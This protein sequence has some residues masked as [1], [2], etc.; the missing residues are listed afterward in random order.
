ML[1]KIKL[2]IP[3]LSLIF[4]L[5]LP[6]FVLASDGPVDRLTN[7][8]HDSGYSTDARSTSLPEIVGK[9]IGVFLT[10]LGVVFLALLVYAGTLWMIAAGNEDKVTKSKDTMRRSLIGLG[11]VVAAYAISQYIFYSILF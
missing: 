7:V 5:L 8:A 6:Y 4:I 9:V 2:I 1:K 11:I 10:L 3:L